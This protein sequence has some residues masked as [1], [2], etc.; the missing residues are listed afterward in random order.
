MVDQM[1]RL[2]VSTE[3]DDVTDEINELKCTVQVLKDIVTALTH[4]LYG[5]TEDPTLH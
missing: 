2:N 5:N 1:V 3:I 4:E